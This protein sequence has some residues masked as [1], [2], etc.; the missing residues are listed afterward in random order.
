MKLKP[1]V[2]MLVLGFFSGDDKISEQ[3]IIFDSKEDKSNFF[4]GAEED[5][6]TYMVTHFS[7]PGS[8]VLDISCLHGNHRHS[9]LYSAC[10]VYFTESPGWPCPPCKSL[11]H[12]A[13]LRANS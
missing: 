3:H 10:M 1:C 9:A 8:T 13:C 5:F 12:G 4:Y 7:P 6:Y 11:A 2:S